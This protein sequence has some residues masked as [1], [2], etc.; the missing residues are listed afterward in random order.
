MWIS[1]CNT[2]HS[3]RHLLLT[4]E[5]LKTHVL[6]LFLKGMCPVY[7][8]A[9]HSWSGFTSRRSEYKTFNESLQ[10]TFLNNVLISKFHDECGWRLPSL[11]EQ[12]RREGRGEQ[13]SFTFKATFKETV[14]YEQSCFR[15][16]KN[17]SFTLSLIHFNQTMLQTFHSDPKESYQL[18]DK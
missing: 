5:P 15:Q 17:G 6:R 7:L 3:S 16:D 1:E 10:I 18:V 11:R 8:H 13:S 9:N 12:L 4:S 14:C 2:E